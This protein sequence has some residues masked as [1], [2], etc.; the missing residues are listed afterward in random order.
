M[1]QYAVAWRENK[2]KF[3]SKDDGLHAAQYVNIIEPY[4][5]LLAALF[6]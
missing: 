2:N 3:L 4:G 6:F 5:L 1:A